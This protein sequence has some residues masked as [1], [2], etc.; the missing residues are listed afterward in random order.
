MIIH[1]RF[2][3]A[4]QDTVID[5]CLSYHRVS[6]GTWVRWDGRERLFPREYEIVPFKEKCVWE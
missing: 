6:K 1:N 3:H 2:D 4:T 5:T